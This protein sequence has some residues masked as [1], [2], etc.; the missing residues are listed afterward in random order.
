ITQLYNAGLPEDGLQTYRFALSKLVNSLSW[1]PTVTVPVAVDPAR[2]VFRIDLR[3]FKWNEKVGDLILAAYPY[4]AVYPTGAADYCFRET[5]CRLPYVRADWFVFEASRPPLYHQVLR[6]PEIAEE[7]EKRLDVDVAEN[8]R[9]FSVARAGFLGSGVSA[10]NRLIERHPS[11]VTRGA[12]WKSYDFP[13]ATGADAEF[14][15]LFRHPLGPP[16]ERNAFRP[17]GGEII[18]NLPN[19]LQ[20]YML[21]DAD[22]RRI[23]RGPLNVVSDPKQRDKA[24]VTG[25]SCMSC[26][27]RGIIPKDDP[28]P[29][30]VLTTT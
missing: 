11:S 1:H 30:S 15:D 21:T 16:P 20:G 22:G 13:A 27:V 18:F 4:R 9:N 23:D 19:G 2:T 6:M 12:Y 26:H 10:N 14:R 5:P 25:I 17:A 7:L 8:I 3:W 28:I 24:V 29:P